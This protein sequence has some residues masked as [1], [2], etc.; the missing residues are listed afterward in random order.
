MSRQ[1]RDG[2]KSNSGKSTF[3]EITI[4]YRD[5]INKH[6]GAYEEYAGYVPPKLTHAQQS[7]DYECTKNIKAYI[8]NIK[9][10]FGNR[11][12]Q[13]LNLICGKKKKPDEVQKK[14]SEARYDND[15]IKEVIKKHCYYSLYQCKDSCVTEEIAN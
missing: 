1:L 3:K 4:K 14:T 13:V 2:I 6:A 5:S 8:N 15:A 10:H 11:L 12:C 9:A 7:A